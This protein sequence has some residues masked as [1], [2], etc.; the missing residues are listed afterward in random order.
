MIKYCCCIMMLVVGMPAQLCFSNSEV[1][2]QKITVDQQPSSQHFP[3]KALR[4]K[5]NGQVIIKHGFDANG[6]VVNPIITESTPKKWFDRSAL[7]ALESVRFRDVNNTGLQALSTVKFSADTRSIH[8]S[9]ILTNE[10][11]QI[12]QTGQSI[13]KTR[14]ERRITQAKVNKPRHIE[15]LGDS[16][17]EK[18]IESK[19][20]LQFAPTRTMTPGQKILVD[21]VTYGGIA[22]ELGI[23]Q[24]DYLAAVNGYE[25][26]K[27]SFQVESQSFFCNEDKELRLNMY[28]RQVIGNNLRAYSKTLKGPIDSSGFDCEKVF[29]DYKTAKVRVKVLNRIYMFDIKS[30]KRFPE[31]NL[32]FVEWFVSTDAYQCGAGRACKIRLLDEDDNV[33]DIFAVTGSVMLRID[34]NYE[35]EIERA[36]PLSYTGYMQNMSVNDLSLIDRRSGGNERDIAK[37]YTQFAFQYAKNCASEIVDMGEIKQSFISI[38]STPFGRDYETDRDEYFY[39]VEKAFITRTIDYMKWYGSGRK[40]LSDSVKMFLTIN[41]CSSKATKNLRKNLITFGKSHD[42][43]Y[44]KHEFGPVAPVL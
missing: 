21:A 39:P 35:F 9:S 1:K 34:D 7:N 18:L 14:T 23:I 33:T 10:Q 31:D 19:L 4:R 41:G 2:Q 25:L 5:M 11:R 17:F 22:A 15:F 3:R 32:Q 38:E 13:S 44:K 8:I 6:L 40:L 24:G 30:R 27:G 28:R 29:E 20:G 26:K 12:N 37:I 16:N 36:F 42:A 43:K